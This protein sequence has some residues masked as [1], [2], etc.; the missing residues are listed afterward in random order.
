MINNALANYAKH[1]YARKNSKILDYLAHSF[2]ND[3]KKQLAF[4][5]YELMNA[6]IKGELL[7][8]INNIFSMHSDQEHWFYIK[9]FEKRCARYFTKRYAIGTSSGTT[10]LQLSLLSQGIGKGDEVITVPNTYI[11]TALAISSIDA[12]PVFV[13]ISN[14]TYN[15]DPSLLS[16]AISS[17]TKAIIPVHLY[18]NPCE[19]LEIKKIAKE[20]NLPII[21]DCCQA[22]GAEYLSNKVPYTSTGCFSFNTSKILGGIG[23]GGMILTNDYK[24]KDTIESM[25]ELE[26]NS[27]SVS[28]NKIPTSKLDI[29]Q[30]AILHV[31]LNHLSDWIVKRRKNAALYK[32]MLNDCGVILPQETK[33]SMHVYSSFVIRS[34]KRDKL[35]SFMEKN[36]IETNIEFRNPLH[37]TKPFESL[38]YQNG[39]FPN[40]EK[41]SQEILSLPI[42]SFLSE[43][44]IQRISKL[45]VQ[46]NRH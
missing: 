45:I 31:K 8:E 5:H 24:I 12:K 41:I 13:D 18:G 29:I 15:M 1:L 46:F 27:K 23:N 26:S 35:K 44:H 37:L 32:G 21:E 20:H 28:L 36:K 16:D 19:M 11:A 2:I 40:T 14:A 6:E 30:A 34:G 10:A 39:D 43:E 33:H 42:S 3:K 4:H 9:N 7:E 17:R 25:T 38:G 22:H